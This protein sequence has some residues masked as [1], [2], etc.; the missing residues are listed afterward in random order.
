[1]L[2]TTTLQWLCCGAGVADDGKLCYLQG[3]TKSDHEIVQLKQRRSNG[4]NKPVNCDVIRSAPLQNSPFISCADTNFTIRNRIC[5]NLKMET[6]GPPE[7]PS[8]TRLCAP[9]NQFL[10]LLNIIVYFAI[11]LFIYLGTKKVSM[12]FQSERLDFQTSIE[13]ACTELGDSWA[14]KIRRRIAFAQVKILLQL[15]RTSE[16]RNKY[17]HNLVHK[18]VNKGVVGAEVN[19]IGAMP[20]KT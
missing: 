3:A 13:R 12:F 5:P 15:V 19:F 11:S 10:T 1:M 16:R 8:T 6:S 2:L 20:P 4:V 9:V 18:A 17:Q 7:P 14:D